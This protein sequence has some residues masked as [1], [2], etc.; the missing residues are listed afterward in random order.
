MFLGVAPTLAAAADGATGGKGG[1]GLLLLAAEVEDDSSSSSGSGGSGLDWRL[2]PGE[3]H[4][5]AVG[6]WQRLLA[7]LQ[8]QQQQQQ[9][10]QPPQAPTAPTAAAALALT[11]PLPGLQLLLGYHAAHHGCDRL[12]SPREQAVLGAVRACS[13]RAQAALAL[14]LSAGPLPR[15]GSRDADAGGT[16][17]AL[18]ALLALLDAGVAS[19]TV[20]RRGAVRALRVVP[21]LPAAAGGPSADAPAALRE[22]EARGLVAHQ[23]AWVVGDVVKEAVGRLAFLYTGKWELVLEA[24]DDDE[25]EEGFGGGKENVPQAQQQWQQQWQLS[26]LQALI[27]GAVAAATAAWGLEATGSLTALAA[28]LA[29]L[30]GH[31]L[32]LNGGGA[33]AEEE[34]VGRGLAHLFRTREDWERLLRARRWRCRMQRAVW[35]GAGALG[36]QA[37]RAARGGGRGGGGGRDEAVL[38]LL[39]QVMWGLYPKEPAGGGRAAVGIKD[40]GACVRA[41]GWLARVVVV[42]CFALTPTPCPTPKKTTTV[43]SV[44]DAEVAVRD[45]VLAGGRSVEVSALVYSCTWQWARGILAGASWCVCICVCWQGGVVGVHPYMHDQPPLV[46]PSI[47]HSAGSGARA[48]SIRP[49]PRTSSACSCA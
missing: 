37:R 39:R 41:D 6:G 31:S 2:P 4:V 22:L 42:F 8:L 9:Q 5:R 11:N 43:R 26:G 20:A 47:N 33:P 25:K 1:G 21:P 7:R 32:G 13:W 23:R 29:L 10:E 28:T 18:W 17:A 45:A 38:R 36:W 35:G 14:L 34:A 48:A 30:G 24:E 46:H 19:K 3:A 49:W 44:I 12:F 27:Q 16:A 15:L 40:Y